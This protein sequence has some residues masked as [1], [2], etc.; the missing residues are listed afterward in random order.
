MKN[1]PSEMTPYRD[2][3][4]NAEHQKPPLGECTCDAYSRGYE[5]AKEYY[6]NSCFYCGYAGEWSTYACDE[7]I[8]RLEKEE[9]DGV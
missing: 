1:N 4:C 6:T 8:E 3:M 7:C 5:E 2:P 9:E